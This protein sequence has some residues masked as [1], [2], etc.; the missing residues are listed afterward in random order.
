MMY[1]VA[2]FVPKWAMH[3]S[4]LG[5]EH[6]FLYYN[7]SGDNLEHITASRL[8]KYNMSRYVMPWEKTHEEGFSYCALMAREK[9]E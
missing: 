5:V 3:N 8:S 6:F 9:L 2:K 7:D 1:N 4:H